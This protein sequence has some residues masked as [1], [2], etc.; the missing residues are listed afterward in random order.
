M[1][2]PGGKLN[3]PGGLFQLLQEGHQKNPLFWGPEVVFPRGKRVCTT[4]VVP[5]VSRSVARPRGHRA[6]TNYSVY[7]LPGRTREKGYFTIHHRSGK[8]DIH[9]RG[10]RPDKKKKGRVST[11]VVYTFFFLLGK[12]KHTPPCS[13]AELFFAEKKNGPQ[14]KDF[15]GGYGFPGFHWDFVSTTDLDSFSLWPEKFPK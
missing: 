1:W 13:S 11:V 15:G 10:L 14:R 5:L 6:K 9:H 4:T 7:H 12:R 3:T 2:G 8:K